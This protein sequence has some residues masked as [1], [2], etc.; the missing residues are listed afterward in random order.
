MSAEIVI[1]FSRLAPLDRS[2]FVLTIAQAT[3]FSGS[4][5]LTFLGQ[6]HGCSK[7]QWWRREVQQVY[8]RWEVEVMER[9][10]ELD[11]DTKSKY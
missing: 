5:W 11:R 7:L 4:A 8:V 3:F 10:R 1:V 6:S 2:R 9:C